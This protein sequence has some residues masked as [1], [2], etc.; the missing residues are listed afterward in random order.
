[1]ETYGSEITFLVDA[2]L[3]RNHAACWVGGLEGEFSG[4]GGDDPGLEGVGGDGG[5]VGCVWV[6]GGEEGCVA[7]GGV[8]VF[9]VRLYV[10]VSYLVLWTRK[11]S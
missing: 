4:G 7:A 10:C 3:A 6:G 9:V 1:M 5:G 11:G 2:E 8:E